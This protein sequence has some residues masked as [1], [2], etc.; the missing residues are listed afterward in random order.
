MTQTVTR[1]ERQQQVREGTRRAILDAALE[2]FVT[3]GYP[4]VS[5]RNIAAKVE[6]SPGAIYSYFPSKDEIFFALAEEGFRMLGASQLGQAQS[7][8]P[9]ADLGA[10]AW[11]FFE[12]SKAQP[13]YFAL[14]FLD[15][16]VPRIGREFER[17]AFMADLK[18]QLRARVRLCIDEGLLPA[19][20]D[21]DVALRLLWS[22]LIGIASMTLSNRIPATDDSDA[23]VRASIAT[24]IAGLRAGS[25]NGL[26]SPKHC[27]VG[28]ADAAVTR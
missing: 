3:D 11:Q 21:P 10:V 17:F 25:A 28:A 13:Q 8:D 27:S 6:Y 5:I 26:L 4:Q 7:G 2:L 20:L 23:L 18:D 16:H 12:F 1:S 22:P 24:T 9:L 19:E 14:V 15:R